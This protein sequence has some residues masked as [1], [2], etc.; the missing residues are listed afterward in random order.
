[1]PKLGYNRQKEYK[2]FGLACI[3][4]ITE[5]Y[6]K[7]INIENKHNRKDSFLSLVDIFNQIGFKS[8]LIN[9]SF[10][11]LQKES[12][13]C[14][15]KWDKANYVV[16]FGIKS[17]NKGNK[18]VTVSHPTYGLIDYTQDLFIKAWIGN[19]ANENT[20]EGVT[21]LVEPTSKFYNNWDNKNE[22][23]S[24]KHILKYIFKYRSFLFQLIIGFFTGSL[25]QLITPFL[26]QS[27]ID[28]GIKN[29][30]L[31]FVY[32]ILIAMLSLFI[33]RTLIEILRS[34]I[35]LHLSTRVNISLI[36]DFILKIMNL[37]ISFFD[38]KLTGDFLQR[39]ND[40]KRIEQILNASSLNLMFSMFNLIVFCFI[41]IY[42]SFLIFSVFVLGSIFYFAW[43]FL[44]FKK[45]KE[46]D[47]QRFYETS[48]EQSKVIE[49]L[50]GM[51][52]IKLHNAEKKK[53]WGLVFVQTKIL[54]ISIKSLILE[55]YQ[56]VGST[57]INEFKNI[58]ITFLSAYLVINGDIT[59]GMMIAITLIV[60]QLNNP[61]FQL[62]NF[63]FQLQDAQISIERL[64]EI[65][66]KNDEDYPIHEKTKDINE[67]SDFQIKNL[68]FKYSESDKLVL[69]NINLH[70]PANKITAVVGA[71]GSGKTTLMKLLLKFYEP[72]NGNI[73]VGMNNLKNI[74]QKTWRKHLGAVM[75]EGYIFNDTIAN[76][77][78][79]AEDYVDKK[80]LIHALD[81]A[82][83]KEFVESLPLSYNTKIGMEGVGLSVGQKQRFLIARA[84][85]KNP[86]ILFFDEATSALDAN[87][88]RIIM[89]GLDSFFRDK[90]V[91][92]IA[93]RLS[94]VRNANQIVVLDNG[95]ITEVGD[96]KTL[97]K[98]KGDYYDIVKNQLELG[99]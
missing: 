86:K 57:F 64:G 93:H 41:L 13:P 97:I 85:Y 24:Y 48:K 31:S 10:K 81:V 11:E 59:L 28:V 15:I 47:Y 72:E 4:I 96:H 17:P 34:W 44:F 49:L 99:N 84:V 51:Q 42:Y 26:T 7:V 58:V 88:E 66:N 19:G 1:M 77:I 94:T 68:S 35:L 3:K 98:K 40:Y 70:I 82:N 5:Y 75:Q 43:L 76:N 89:E 60:G 21:L 9:L 63:L 71:S 65:H 90:T 53:R 18:I 22:K 23:F 29:Q 33:S 52:D 56:T 83:L 73:L 12:L 14:I 95:R 62:I 30:D 91:I 37:P 2:N 46:L 16:V 54:K 20:K 74:S 80:K 50:N 87:N 92:V 38:V 79:I 67:N 27:I 55:Q 6:G 61:I 39:I 45:R 8:L 78:A 36:S 25:L 32:L 69:K